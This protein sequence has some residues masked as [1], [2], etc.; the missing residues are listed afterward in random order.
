MRAAHEVDPEVAEFAGVAPCQTANERHRHGHADGGGDEVLHGQAG[1]LHQVALGRLTRI[2]LP[3]GVGH[4]ADRGVPRQ[5]RGHLGA[6]IVQ[7]QRQ[8]ALH[9]LKD[10]QEQDA[11]RREREHA[12][13]VGAPGLF[14]L[15]VGADQPVNDAFAAQ[16]LLGRV[17]PVHVVAQRHMDGRECDDQ[18]YEEQDPRC[19]G[20]HLEPLGEE[21]GGEEEQ[22]DQ[23]REHKAD[24]VVES[25]SL[26]QLLN[27][28]EH[29][30][31]RHRQ[32]DVHQDGHV[33]PGRLQA[34]GFR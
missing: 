19:R 5:R 14:R 16:V 17:D 25:Q 6:G 11:D 21:Q 31:D 30:E 20:T 1:H 2:G 24:D 27:Q 8:L 3:V 32:R 15:R 26:D 28:A 12:A 7:V 22:R 34:A 4:E 23:D 10:E 33:T 18:R 13:C 29:G 9:Q